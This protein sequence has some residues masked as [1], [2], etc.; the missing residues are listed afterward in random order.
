M[1]QQDFYKKYRWF[2]TKS[3]KLVYGGKSA[4]QNELIVKELLKQFQK[5]KKDYLLMHT[6]I[7]GSPFAVIRAPISKISERDLQ[8]TAIWTGCFSR[9]WRQ[10]MKS[11]EVDI[12]KLSNVKKPSKLKPGTFSVS[13]KDKTIKVN[14]KLVLIN[15]KSLLRAVPEITPKKQNNILAKITSGSITKDKFAEQLSKQLGKPK[16]EVLN[17][18]PTGG[19]KRI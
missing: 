12:F 4:E 14:L 11:V 6:K 13:K 8:E 19:F 5:T 9:A 1:K 2:F 17:A 16:E 7:P 18:L 3:N 15:Q 10:G